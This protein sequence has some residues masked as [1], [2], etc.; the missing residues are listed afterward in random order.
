MK[1]Y[2]VPEIEI[3]EVS[4][5]DIMSVSTIVGG[6]NVSSNVTTDEYGNPVYE[7]RADISAITKPQ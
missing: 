5:E 7:G 3:E 4:S 1:K 6:N 2:I